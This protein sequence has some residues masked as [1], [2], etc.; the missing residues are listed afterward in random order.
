MRQEALKKLY[1]QTIP[2]TNTYKWGQPLST[3]G[4]NYLLVDYLS[5]TN[6]TG[7]VYFPLLNYTSGSTSS[8]DGVERLSVNDT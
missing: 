3:V 8:F 4:I 2:S 1:L 7:S 5:P 6:T